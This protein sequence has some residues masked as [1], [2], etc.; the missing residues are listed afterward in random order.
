VL[1]A[2]LAEVGVD[3]AVDAVL[4]PL[5]WGWLGLPVALGVPLLFGV[6]RKELSLVMI[7]QALGNTDLAAALT[8]LQIFTFLVFLTLYVPC[9]STFAVMVKAVGRREAALSVLLS[10]GVA[11][12]AGGV[13]RFA[14]APFWS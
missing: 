5:T 11:L 2:L 9:L 7:Y 8:P 10:V 13:V 1:L 3:R 12:A 14:L 4:S 6:L